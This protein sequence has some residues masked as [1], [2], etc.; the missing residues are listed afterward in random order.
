MTD[1]ATTCDLADG[2]LDLAQPAT[3]GDLYT[4][5][6]EGEYWVPSFVVYWRGPGAH[7]RGGR[8]PPWDLRNII[9]QGFFR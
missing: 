9:Y 4:A 3:W 1:A 2:Y 6:G 8:G 7:P 5:D